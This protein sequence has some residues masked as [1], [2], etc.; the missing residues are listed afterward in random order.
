M[1]VDSDEK[2]LNRQDAPAVALRAMSGKKRAK[3]G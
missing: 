2:N 1:S 3:D